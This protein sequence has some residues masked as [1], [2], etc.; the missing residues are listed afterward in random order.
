MIRKPNF[1]IIG[2]PKCGT[3]SLASWLSK[4]PNIYVSPIKE[5]HF[6]NT[7]LNC[8][9]IRDPKEYEQL[10]RGASEQHMAVGEASV[11]YL[12]SQ[13]AVPRIEVEHPDARYIVMVRNPIEMAYSLWEQQVFAGEEHISDFEEAWHLSEERSARRAITRWT[14]EPKLLDYKS[15]C[16]LGE[17]LQR[18]FNVVPK[19]RVLVLVLDDIKTDPRSQYLRVLDFLGVPDDGRREFAVHNP[20]KERRWPALRRTVQFVLAVR[21]RLG[22]P[23][24]NT[25]VLSKLDKLNTRYRPRPPLPRSIRRA[26]V[27]YFKDDVRLLGQLI[28]RDLSHWLNED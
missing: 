25:G 11:F 18:L 21:R 9:K 8:V 22:I 15:V 16:R 23:R 13:V 6:Y 10:F 4:H 17:Q 3:T 14:R 12:F 19:D 27:E 28:G 5:P 2:A 1:F 24:L 20:A 7:D 26:M